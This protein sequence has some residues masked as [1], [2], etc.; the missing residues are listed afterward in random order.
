[1]KHRPYWPLLHNPTCIHNDESVSEILH[2]GKV[3]SDIEHGDVMLFGK[4]AHG[5]KDVGLCRDIEAGRRFIEN[6]AG[7][8]AGEC[9]RDAHPL[10]LATGEFV[11]VS[12]EQPID[13]VESGISKQLRESCSP[14]DTGFR[15]MCLHGLA[16]VSTDCHAWVECGGRILR[17]IG[18]HSA[19]RG[20]ERSPGQ[21]QNVDAVDGDAAMN[22]LGTL[23]RVSEHR[24]G[25]R[26]L[27]RPG[28]T[29]QAHDL[30]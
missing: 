6:D 4:S 16:Q 9:H 21:T 17:N 3:M 10:P 5:G 2:D 22:D 12:V 13:V 18:D 7:G 28:L 20:A 8:L 23:A 11:R 27:A 25:H 14:I 26:G 1:M 30:T 19:S 29:H 24:G 15:L